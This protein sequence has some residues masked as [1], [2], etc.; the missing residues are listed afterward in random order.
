MLV[1]CILPFVDKFCSSYVGPA[2]VPEFIVRE[3][4]E[5]SK[6]LP[7]L[8]KEE[9]ILVL[10]KVFQVRSYPEA[11]TLKEENARDSVE[12]K[13][14]EVAL[15][16][17]KNSSD[18]SSLSDGEDNVNDLGGGRSDIDLDQETTEA[19]QSEQGLESTNTYPHTTPEIAE[20][21]NLQEG[22]HVTEMN[23]SS[24]LNFLNMVLSQFQ[25]EEG[26]E[27]KE[28]EL[29]VPEEDFC[30]ICMEEYGDDCN[31]TSGTQ[32]DHL[33]HKHCMIKWME[34]KDFCPFCRK[35]M[36]TVGEFEEAA[37]L[38]LDEEIFRKAKDESESRAQNSAIA[39]EDSLL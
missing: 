31:V 24:N 30:P 8:T 16:S 29:R 15:T 22:T 2:W 20:G 7:S 39:R 1:I 17:S 18:K 14:T 11:K 5:S 21:K 37:G 23:E 4:D 13:N 10:E 3:S 32:C 9:R 35:D 6:F 36:M 27:D 34:K 28:Q 25:K 12:E 38:V 19:S 33:F 26:K